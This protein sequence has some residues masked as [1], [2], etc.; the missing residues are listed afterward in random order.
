MSAD[1]LQ[2]KRVLPADI[3]RVFDAWRT[4]EAMS[5]WFVCDHDWTATATNDFRVGG[6][7]RVEMRNGERTVGV[8]SG[9]Y[10]EI[11][12]PR[13]LVFTWRSEGPVGIDH[14]IVTIEL[15]ALGAKTEL[16]LRH[17]IAPETPP[18]RAHAE[19]W[20]GCLA[21]LEQYLE[22]SDDS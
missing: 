4:A 5:R 16:S 7:Y 12:P 6:K 21:N 22:N 15:K 13:R 17:D 8:A 19:G 11:D 2:L 10:R 3:H 14:S 1:V 9:E 20:R 18:G